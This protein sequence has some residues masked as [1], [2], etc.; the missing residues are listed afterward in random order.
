MRQWFLPAISMAFSTRVR[1]GTFDF[2][3]SAL[4]LRRDGMPLKLQAQPA[5]VLA[6]LLANREDVVTRETLRQAVWGNE[7]F[8]DFDRG[9]N[10]CISQVRAALG[11]SAESPLYIRTV[12]K[13]GY[14]FIAPV[15]PEE[16]PATVPAARRPRGWMAAAALLM[17]AVAGFGAF[18]LL[19]PSIPKIAVAHFDNE[20]GDPSLDRFAQSFHDATVAELTAQTA[21]EYG[22]I[23][24]AA[25]LQLPRKDRDLLAIASTLQ[26]GFVVLGQVQGDP[27]SPRVLIHLIRLPDQTHLTV[28]RR[29]GVDLTSPGTDLARLTASDFI[30]RFALT[31]AATKKKT[32]ELSTHIELTATLRRP[33]AT[34][35]PRGAR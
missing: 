13:R 21:G 17:L 11:D 34:F 35:A 24:N 22:I 15:T 26:A 27:K 10:F 20:T 2:D 14:Q 1:F 28:T 25:I 23:G 9:L 3:P 12:P 6:V 4:E 32:L 5:Q 18:R 31:S 33:R 8:V 7:T 29:E 16:A 30:G 19:T